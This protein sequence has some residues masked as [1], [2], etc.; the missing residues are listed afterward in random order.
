M[1]DNTLYMEKY[2]TSAHDDEH[3]DVNAYYDDYDPSAIVDEVYSDLLQDDTSTI[4]S[5]WLPKILRQQPVVS[6]LIKVFERALSYILSQKSGSTTS[7]LSMILIVMVLLLAPL[8][9]LGFFDNDDS[10]D[11]DTP[12]GVMLYRSILRLIDVT[13]SLCMAPFDAVLR[14]LSP[15]SYSPLLADDYDDDNDDDDARQQKDATVKGPSSRVRILRALA[16]KA[17]Q[18]TKMPPLVPIPGAKEE[19]PKRP[20]LKQ[21]QPPPE[22]EPAFL[23]PQD[24]P[25]GWLVYH[26][27][28]G[29][30]A[31]EEADAYD[32]Q[33][34]VMIK[35]SETE[36][37]ERGGAQKEPDDI[38]DDSIKEP[39]E[40][41]TSEETTT[42]TITKQVSAS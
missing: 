31:K 18:P 27:K 1:E 8:A 24:Y 22:L 21:P 35:A 13:W 16:G 2:D 15:A 30:V 37:G 39:N 33:G 36:T 10:A 42:S 12:Y 9:I 32:Q 38:D 28:L 34:E 17:T 5:S 29:V 11:P 41:S 3:V 25:P 7:T 26:P 19:L 6:W 4:I 40:A 23:N 20:S 14:L